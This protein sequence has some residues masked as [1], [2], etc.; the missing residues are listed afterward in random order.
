MNTQIVIPLVVLIAVWIVVGLI[1]WVTSL[2]FRSLRL[3]KKY[4][5]EYDYTLQKLGDRR[6]AEADLK[7]RE[8]RVHHL[9][10]H[11]LS[12]NERQ[13]YQ[14]EWTEIQADFVNDPGKSIEQANRVITEVMIARG[15]PVEDFEQ[16]TADISVLY[17]SFAPK[18]R[19]ANAVAV[20]SKE[21]VATTEDLRQAMLDYRSLFSQILGAVET[22][23][24]Q[25]QPVKQMEAT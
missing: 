6:T 24:K 5:P 2:R 14:T 18:Y 16:R 22:T 15:F 7:E 19:R 23:E 8:Q 12:D 4:G 13:R 20:K 11:D 25:R 9:D 21:G 3:K 10:I 1:I 17:P